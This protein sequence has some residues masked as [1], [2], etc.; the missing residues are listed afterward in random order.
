MWRIA[1]PGY[2]SSIKVASRRVRF[3]ISL[4]YVF[5]YFT[6]ASYSD[7]DMSSESGYESNQESVHESDCDN[8]DKDLEPESDVEEFENALWDPHAQLHAT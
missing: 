6:I 5:I 8:E 2:A 4:L 7:S 1:K 3:N